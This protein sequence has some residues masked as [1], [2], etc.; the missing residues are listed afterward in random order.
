MGV[1]ENKSFE[2][3]TRLEIPVSI[4]D[5]VEATNWAFKRGVSLGLIQE[6]LDDWETRTLLKVEKK[7]VETPKTVKP[8]V[9]KKTSTVSTVT[10][11]AITS[12]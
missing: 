10:T 4:T 1:R 11:P 2:I 12:K 3:E 9:A 7:K 5:E 6:Y 8:I